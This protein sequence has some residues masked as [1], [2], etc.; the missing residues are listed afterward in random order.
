M[1]E[2]FLAWLKSLSGGKKTAVPQAGRTASGKLDRQTPPPQAAEAATP[3]S[4]DTLLCREAVLT[5]DQRI[6]GYQFM[7][8]E[9]TRNRI[10]SSS[11]RIRH[12]YAETLVRTLACADLGRL[13]DHRLIFIDLPDSFLDHPALNGLPPRNTVLAVE[14]LEDQ[15]TPAASGLSAT[16]GQLR[17]AGFRIAIPDPTVVTAS[18]ALLPQADIVFAHAAAS[19]A[20]HLRRLARHLD[21][22]PKPPA[23]LIRSLQGQEDFDFCY[24]RGAR[25]FQGPFVT[26]SGN[27]REKPPGPNTARLAILIGRLKDDTSTEELAEWL[28]R[29][30]ALSLRLLRYINSAD[31]GRGTPITSIGHALIML[32]RSRLRRWLMLLLCTAD[33][34]SPRSAA[35]LESALVRARM[36]ETLIPGQPQEERDA[37]FLAGL[38]SLIDAVLEIPMARAVSILA[39]PPGVEAAVLRGDGPYAPLLQLAIACEQ[40]GDGDLADIAERCGVT[41]EA[42]TACHLAALAWA[43]SFEE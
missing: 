5:R 9:T 2:K 33:Q 24:Q 27:W 30:A 8:Q 4:V 11:R 29:D 1:L 28:K 35:A 38:M 12:I 7:L 32:G 3:R 31:N 16:I 17:A 41:P 34:N 19:S 20:G 21:G 10:R 39:L 40:T 15:A 13:P 37:L 18:E 36:M 14:H 43:L 6:A 25:F 42:A 22:M 26:R 23:L